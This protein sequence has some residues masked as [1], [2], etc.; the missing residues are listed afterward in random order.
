MEEHGYLSWCSN[1]D[2]GR[3]MKECRFDSRQSHKISFCTTASQVALE[4]FHLPMLWIPDA[5]SMEV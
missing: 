4:P 2:I 3:T 5:A 1:S